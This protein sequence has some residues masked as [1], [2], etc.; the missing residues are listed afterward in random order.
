MSFEFKFFG[1]GEL[2]LSLPR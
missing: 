1:F 2:T